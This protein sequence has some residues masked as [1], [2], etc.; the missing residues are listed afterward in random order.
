M[1][2][3]SIEIKDEIHPLSAQLL[4]TA[5]NLYASSDEFKSFEDG[6]SLIG[7]N[8]ELVVLEGMKI[9]RWNN[10]DIP[11]PEMILEAIEYAMKWCQEQSENEEDYEKIYD[12][13]SD[14]VAFEGLLVI[15]KNCMEL[16]NYP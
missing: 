10:R 14:F 16:K 13:T 11:L 9:L 4:K 3:S 15:C 8:I 1:I 6:L 7:D 2:I 12:L 5:I